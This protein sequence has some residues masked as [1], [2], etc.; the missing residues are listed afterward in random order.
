MSRRLPSPCPNTSPTRRRLLQCL[1]GAPLLAL[2]LAPTARGSSPARVVCVGGAL[3]ETVYALGAQAQL[4]GVDTTSNF[5]T[6]ARQLPSVGYARQLSSEGLLA[7]APTRVL[8]T[9]DAGPPAVLRQL[10]QAGVPLTVLPANKRF[11]GVVQRVQRMGELLGRREAAQAL[12]QQLS[13]QWQATRARVA[14]RSAPAPRVL[15]VMSHGPSQMMVSGRATS[16]DA[17]LAYAGARNV[18]QGFEGY[19]PLTPEALIAA[20]PDVLLLTE[21]GYQAMGGHDGALQL[22]GL[23]Q[24]P[25]G[26]HGRVLAM[27]TMYLLGFGPRLPAAVAELDAR[28][29]S[30]MQGQRP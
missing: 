15:F 11:E 19:K 21:Q 4:V 30:A 17:V 14:G 5:P 2:T 28:L 13:T 16:A 18:V 6:A 9:E 24:T 26:R 27:E 12:A 7:L 10:E 8:A 22:P 29:H 23:A 25:A 3:T 1:S 20:Q